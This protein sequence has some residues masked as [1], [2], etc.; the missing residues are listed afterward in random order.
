MERLRAFNP[1]ALMEFLIGPLECYFTRRLLD[2]AYNRNAGHTRLFDRLLSRMDNVSPDSIKVL[3]D[4]IYQ[5]PSSKLN[6]I[7]I[8]DIFQLLVSIDFNC[9]NLKKKLT[10][11][12]HKNKFILKAPC[13]KCTRTQGFALAPWVKVVHFASTKH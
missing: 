9:S 3:D 8:L 13:T 4:H 7:F 1:C 2:H 6:G 5:V 10:I 11:L 12:I